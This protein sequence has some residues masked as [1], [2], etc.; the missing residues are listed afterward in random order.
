MGPCYLHNAQ[1]FQRMTYLQAGLLKI[2]IKLQKMEYI[3]QP[4][5]VYQINEEK[6][7]W[8]LALRQI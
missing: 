1:D 3:Y 5:K 7:K 4:D 8:K 6:G 2:Y